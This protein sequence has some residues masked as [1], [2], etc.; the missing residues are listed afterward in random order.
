N[1]GNGVTIEPLFSPNTKG[2]LPK[3][4]TAPV[5][6]Q[7]LFDLVGSAKQAVLFLAFDPGNNSILD[8]AGAALAKNPNL[9]VRGALTS[10]ERA[11]NFAEALRRGR[12]A[13][14]PDE[15]NLHVAVIGEPGTPTKTGA[16]AA[17]IQPDY[18]AIP[19]GAINDKDAFGVWEKEIY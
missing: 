15:T 13:A 6:M 11:G 18:R 1:L 8:A 3:K 17:P 7:R 4:P 5:D 14:H 10:T 19:A 9:F 16:K 2:L 12:E